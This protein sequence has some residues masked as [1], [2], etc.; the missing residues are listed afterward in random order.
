MAEI[1]EYQEAEKIAELAVKHGVRK[2]Q[3]DELAEFAATHPKDGIIYWLRR[4]TTRGRMD[5]DFMKVLQELLDQSTTLQFSKI[6]SISANYID[7]K[8]GEKAVKT[9]QQ[10]RATIDKIV[11]EYAVR[12]RLGFSKTELRFDRGT[13][14]LDVIVERENIP[15]GDIAFGIQSEIRRKIPELKSLDFKVWI[16]TKEEVRI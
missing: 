12:S 5:V 14:R 3:L 4:Q 16:L 15:K 1:N 13:L 2:H 11:Q 8:A 9:L 7:W 10:Y 6:M